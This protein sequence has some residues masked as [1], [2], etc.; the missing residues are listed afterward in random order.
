MR[1]LCGLAFALMATLGGSFPAAAQAPGR[2]GDKPAATPA[3]ALDLTPWRTEDLLDTRLDVDA[4]YSLM[5]L[6]RGS[7]DQAVLASDILA[8][9]ESGALAGI[10]QVDR[11]APAARAQAL[12]TGWW[13]VI[14]ADRQVLC[15]RAVGSGQAPMIVYRQGLA[16][17]RRLDALIEGAA[18]SCGLPK[19]PPR[20]YVETIHR[21][22]P[23]PTQEAGGEDGDGV[24]VRS[25]VT[26]RAGSKPLQGATVTYRQVSTGGSFSEATNAEGTSSFIL[27]GGEEYEITVAAQGFA[28][29]HDLFTMP[30]DGGATNIVFDLERQSEGLGCDNTVF[31]Q[32]LEACWKQLV[33]W[34]TECN[35]RAAKVYSD[36]SSSPGADALSGV[37]G[38]DL[39]CQSAAL[40]QKMACRSGYDSR[41]G[42]CVRSSFE[43]SNCGGGGE[44]EGP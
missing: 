29:E 26:V 7:V 30:S 12:G 41:R 39:T 11:R 31:R 16:G 32:H 40:A 37:P 43:A 2:G 23:K 9:L 14:P 36:C 21:P 25:E 8:A 34:T 15:W 38:V 13:Q 17:S 20:I 27:V 5:R 1:S 24:D 22:P 19:A 42:E 4:Q 3:P 6:F 18:I 10:H 28:T 44:G 35:Q 33:A